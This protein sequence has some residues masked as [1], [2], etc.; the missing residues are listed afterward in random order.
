MQGISREDALLEFY[1]NSI[2]AKK[3]RRN[4]YQSGDDMKKRKGYIFTNKRHSE[5]AIMA[6]LLGI[7]S[8]AA[9]GIVVFRAYQSGGEALQG[10]GVTGILATLFSLTGLILGIVTV[11]DKNSYRIFPVLGI[12]LN[13]LALRQSA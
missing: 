4:E 2:C 9:L 8:L 13:F 1:A 10:Y 12:L 3:V 7:I 6:T 11:R 5:K